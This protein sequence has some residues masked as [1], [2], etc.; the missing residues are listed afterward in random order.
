MMIRLDRRS[1]PFVRAARL[2]GLL[3]GLCAVTLTAGFG[4][5]VADAE[6]RSPWPANADGIVAL[7]GGALRVQTALGLLHA[8]VAHRLLISGA[9]PGV[10][11]Q[12]VLRTDDPRAT[13]AGAITLGHVA[14]TTAGNAVEAAWWVRANGLH[15]LVVVT[16]GY[17][18]RRALAEIGAAAPHIRL[19]PYAVHP[20]AGPRTFLIEYA[21]LIAT[22]GMPA[23][24]PG[25]T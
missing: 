6:R 3:A 12:A 25:T 5:F 18:M 1:H 21:K 8:G 22:I 16:A 2:A 24:A 4:W 7:T 14:K 15:S 10:T 23:P 20:H 17:H 11:V 13:Q 19:M 9:A